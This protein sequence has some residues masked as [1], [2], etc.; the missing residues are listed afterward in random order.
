MSLSPLFSPEEAAQARHGEM[1]AQLNAVSINY[2]CIFLW[3]K[4]TCPD[5]TRGRDQVRGRVNYKPIAH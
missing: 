1:D 4:L 3:Y 5:P 2:S